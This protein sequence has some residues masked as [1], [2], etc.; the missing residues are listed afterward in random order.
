MIFLIHGK[1][2]LK[3][4][5]ELEN[6]R[7]KEKPNEVIRIALD[8][9]TPAEFSNSVLTPNMFGFKN[10]VIADTEEISQKDLIE[11]IEVAK[12]ASKDNL[13]AFTLNKNLRSNSKIIKELKETKN[14]KTIKVTEE[15]DYTIFNFLDAVYSKDR[16]KAY[17]LL[18]DLNQIEEPP[19][20][21]Q[22]MLVYQLRKI[23]KVTFGAEISGPPFVK[24]KIKKQANNFNKEELTKL[25]EHFYKTDRD[26]KLGLIP[27]NILNIMS[28]EKIMED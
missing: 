7:N 13:V 21:I 26:M 18:E 16:K 1:D 24:R 5:E 8:E 11:F 2:S 25:Y 12:K 10:L 14:T 23:A 6:I 3:I 9:V 17:K 20:K 15:K 4:Q 19:F 27:E 22:S 28:I